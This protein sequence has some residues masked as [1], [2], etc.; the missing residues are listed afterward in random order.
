MLSD[1]SGPGARVDEQGYLTGFPLTESG[2]Y[3]LA[4]TWPAPEMPRPGCVWTHTL[5]ID[6]ADLAIIKSLSVISSLFRRPQLSSYVDYEKKMILV[7]QMA[8][9]PLTQKDIVW[10]RRLLAGLYGKPRSR[11]VAMRQ[12]GGDVEALVLALWSQQWPRLRRAFRFCT[13]ATADRSSDSQHFDLQLLPP[14][15]RSIRTRFHGAVDAESL[16]GGMDSWLDETVLDLLE[17]DAQGLRSFLHR[18]GGDVLRGRE[19]FQPLCRLHQLISVFETDPKALGAAVAI[20]DNEL[21]P[22]EARVARTVV[23]TAGISHAHGLDHDIL[24][25][26]FRNIDL[27]DVTSL[28][29]GADNFGRE[30]WKLDPYRLLSL[31]ESNDTRRIIPERTI[32]VLQLDEL[33][34]GLQRSDALIKPVLERRPELTTQPAFWAIDGL[35]SEVALSAISGLNELHLPSLEAIIAAR[36]H[37]LASRCIPRF[38]SFTV[39]QVIAP[40]IDKDNE[41]E[42]SHWIREAAYDRYAVAEFMASNTPIS[43]I[44][45]VVLARTLSPDAVPNEYGSDPWWLAMNQA[46]GSASADDMIFL[47]GYLLCRALGRVSRNVADLARLGFETTYRAIECNKLPYDLWL[48]LEKRLPMTFPWFDWDRCTRLRS[49]VIDLFVDRRLA[50]EVFAHLVD[51]DHLFFELVRQSCR[52]YRNR[53]FLEKVCHALEYEAGDR[54]FQR[55]SYIQQLLKN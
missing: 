18:L 23:A 31:L 55:I 41:Q 19:G 35:D 50:P 24:E 49:A 11:V 17:P 47:S 42:F 54:S 1:I 15:D 38:G 34:N 28:E 27:V 16:D 48:C 36:R 12:E 52:V 46:T 7:E 51:D 3:A 25:F 43:R 9:L 29:K 26:L 40:Q 44:F 4:R 33:L 8:A 53:R 2:M 5:L 32:A 37:D 39:M 20:L 21:G 6:F 13:W 14:V 45:L 30:I 22:N 10:G